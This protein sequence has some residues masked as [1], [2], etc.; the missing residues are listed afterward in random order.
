[1]S[2]QCLIN[3]KASQICWLY[4]HGEFDEK[5][6][7]DISDI[8]HK[9]IDKRFAIPMVFEIAY[10]IGYAKSEL[11]QYMSETT[12]KRKKMQIRE[13]LVETVKL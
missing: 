6:N 8:A 9:N 1:M 4:L 13:K 11:M 3:D 2:R 5:T 7:I 10:R 12:Y